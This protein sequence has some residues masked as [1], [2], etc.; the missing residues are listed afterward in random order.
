MSARRT[1][2]A[3]ALVRAAV[4]AGDSA[5]DATAGN[6]HDTLF[7][8]QCVGPNGRVFAFDVQPE[9]IAATRAAI[10]AADPGI[11]LRVELIGENHANMAERLPPAI[12]GHVA[13][14]MFNLG[15]LPGGD[16][17]VTTHV[18]STV[19]AVQ[20]GARLLRP[21]G[22]MT[23]LGYVG[24]AAGRV[25]VSA[26]EDMLRNGSSQVDW[27]E[28]EPHAAPSNAPRLFVGIRL[29]DPPKQAD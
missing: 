20:A 7:L 21:G 24:H 23:V 1:T 19:A 13:A 5:I 2:Q 16:K 28:H 12:H 10:D 9:A 29:S 8:A 17:S 18:S 11:A 6:G 26:L 27:H 15:Y 3:H 25:E 4:R 22:L 14:I